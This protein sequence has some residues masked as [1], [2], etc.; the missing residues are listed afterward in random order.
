MKDLSQIPDGTITTVP[1]SLLR[2]NPLNYEIYGEE[3]V[4]P[5]MLKSVQD[6]GIDTPIEV[7]PD[8]MIVKGHR[9]KLHA[10]H[11]GLS[12]VPVVVRRSLNNAEEVGFALIEDNRHQRNRSNVQKV[13]EI[14]YLTELLQTQN[15][16]R[17]ASGLPIY[18]P[19]AHTDEELMELSGMTRQS[20]EK[21]VELTRSYVARTGSAAS[22]QDVACDHIGVSKKTFQMGQRA[23][24]TAEAWRSAGNEKKAGL[25]EDALQKGVSTGYGVAQKIGQPGKKA[26]QKKIIKNVASLEGT[27][28]TLGSQVKSLHVARLSIPEALHSQLDIAINHLN[29]IRAELEKVTLAA[30]P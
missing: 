16:I 18:E 2:N 24:K 12:E 6:H 21:V 30:A 4:D 26:D 20:Y 7:L 10:E 25:I 9:R 17:R 19:D 23:I 28:L 27:I 11:A 22:P 14:M 29:S 3:S 8:G 5:D 15:R 13:R 1:I